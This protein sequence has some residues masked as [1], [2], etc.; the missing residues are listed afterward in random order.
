MTI[1]SSITTPVFTE[2][3]RTQP[4]SSI[5]WHPDVPLSAATV[6]HYARDLFHNYS[7]QGSIEKELVIV[8]DHSE[9]VRVQMSIEH[10]EADYEQYAVSLRIEVPGKDDR[11]MFSGLLGEETRLN[12]DIAS[13]GAWV[14]HPDV[15]EVTDAELQNGRD[16][17]RKGVRK[18]M[19]SLIRAGY[20][21]EVDETQD[22]CVY[23]EVT[24]IAD[25][26]A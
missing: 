4:F 11:V 18:G 10:D 14:L 26:D 21:I 17:S 16:L 5:D 22:P 6:L 3:G 13:M 7:E 12:A 20:P 8:N 2:K 25:P 9:F 1:L 15:Y 23:W 19:A 24:F